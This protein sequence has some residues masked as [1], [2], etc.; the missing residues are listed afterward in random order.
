MC[1]Y[2][3]QSEAHMLFSVFKQRDE[4]KSTATR[5]KTGWEANIEAVICFSDLILQG[6]II[7]KQPREAISFEIVNISTAI[8]KASLP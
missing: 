7:T 2:Y 1:I 5:T 4:Q 6:L 3:L 8:S